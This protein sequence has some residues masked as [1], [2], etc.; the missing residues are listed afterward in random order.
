[1]P[2]PHR[3]TFVRSAAVIA[4]GAIAGLLA[5]RSTAPGTRKRPRKVTFAELE[6]C[7]KAARHKVL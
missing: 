3:K 2:V 5:M 6:R 1:M 4:L 7:A